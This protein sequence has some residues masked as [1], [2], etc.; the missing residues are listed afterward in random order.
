MAIHSDGNNFEHNK[1]LNE[2][3]SSLT[4]F[5]LSSESKESKISKHNNKRDYIARRKIEQLQEEIRLKKLYE[6]DWD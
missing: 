3:E 1:N 4:E 2:L 6:D 5:D